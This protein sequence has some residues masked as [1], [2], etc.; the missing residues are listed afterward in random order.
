MYPRH[1]ASILIESLE[2]SPV[3]LLNGARQTGKTTLALDLVKRGHLD[4]YLSFDDLTLMAAAQSDPTGF[5]NRLEGRT[6]IDEVQRVP[7]VFLPIKATVDR[8]GAKGLFLLTGSANVMVLPAISNALTGRLEIHTLAPL[9]QDELEGRTSRF[10][11]NLL[12]EGKA[13]WRP[14]KGSR[15]VLQRVVRGGFPEALNRERAR[16]RQAWYKGYLT[17]LVQRDLRD[18]AQIE[19]TVEMPRLLRLLAGRVGGLMSY[20]QISRDAGLPQSTLKRYLAHLQ[21]LFVLELLPAWSAN[22]GRRL[23]KSPKTHLIDSGM[24][25]H[26]LGLERLD[27][28]HHMTGS[29][30]ETFV[31]GELRKQ[32]SWNE[33]PLDLFHFRTH[34]G[35]E[36]DFVVEA[37]DGTL[38]GVEVKLGA[39]ARANDFNGLKVLRDLVGPRF[40]RGVVLYGGDRAVPFGERLEA[41]PLSCL[42]S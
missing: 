18:V 22:V 13:R 19:G 34:S 14:P 30:L 27:P 32:T 35:S 37:M 15:H 1:L 11:T 4:N 28:A 23:V 41:V 10:L 39:E 7:E 31:F 3:V 2:D 8:T 36:V 20:A 40:R 12:A 9:S 6:V 21:A 24:A 26:L 29:L 17:T 42:W 25:A 38:G 5:V 16:R 33:R